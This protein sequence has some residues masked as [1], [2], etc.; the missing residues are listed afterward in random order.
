[1]KEKL[2][3]NHYKK[4]G[5]IIAFLSLL[6]LITNIIDQ[7]LVKLK[8]E[9]IDWILKDIFL[10]SL[11]LMAFAREKLENTKLAEIRYEKLKQSVIFGGFVLIM[12]SLLQVIANYQMIQMKGGFHIMVMILLFYLITFNFRKYNYD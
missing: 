9:N 11:L 2:L 7:D 12:D 6:L 8:Q 4:I 10:V 5:L 1:M 3:P